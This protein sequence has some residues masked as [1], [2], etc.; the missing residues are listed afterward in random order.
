[1]VGE[2]LLNQAFCLLSGHKDV[3]R[4][5]NERVHLLKTVKNATLSQEKAVI[6]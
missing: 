3:A 5:E 1:M 4:M 2:T 6:A